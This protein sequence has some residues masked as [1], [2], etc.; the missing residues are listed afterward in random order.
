MDNQSQS[1]F[2]VPALE[3]VIALLQAQLEKAQGVPTKRYAPSSTP[4]PS[5]QLKQH[6][7]PTMSPAAR[8]RIAD[9]QRVRWA[10]KKLD[11]EKAAEP[12]AEPVVAPAPAPTKAPKT[13]KTQTPAPVATAV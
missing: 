12:P 5:P 2:L 11:Q 8:K 9:A 4:A 13:P 7:R 1:N 10:Q 3:T 6:R